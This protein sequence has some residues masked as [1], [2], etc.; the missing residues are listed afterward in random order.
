VKLTT[1][2]PRGQLDLTK[3][4]L[5]VLAALTL[6]C[7]VA[8]AAYGVGSFV[9]SLT[10]DKTNSAEKFQNINDE[11]KAIRGLIENGNFLRRS[12]FDLWC[13]NAEIINRGFKCGNTK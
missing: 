2:G 13:R 1:P 9:N 3:G 11:L 6:L 10:T 8:A 4:S 12:D 5:P 7:F